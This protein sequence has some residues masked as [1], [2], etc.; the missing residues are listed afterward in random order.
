MN[1]SLLHKSKTERHQANVVATSKLT[2]SDY[3]TLSHSPEIC[4]NQ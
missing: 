4:N 3:I 2:V 1:S